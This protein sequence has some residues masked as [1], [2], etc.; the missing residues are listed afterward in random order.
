MEVEIL[1]FDIIVKDSASVIRICG[2]SL[3]K[4]SEN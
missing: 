4:K 1:A 2:V 3:G